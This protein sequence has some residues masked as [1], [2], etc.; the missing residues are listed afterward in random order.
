MLEITDRILNEISAGSARAAAGMSDYVKRL[1]DCME[2]DVPY[3]AN[4]IMEI[5]GLK[6]KE[7]LRRNYLAPALEAG[8]IRMTVPD[9]PTSRNQR[10]IKF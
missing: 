3:S 4:K 9:K 7:N 6:S 8:F 10:Y 2:Y 1:L 5:L